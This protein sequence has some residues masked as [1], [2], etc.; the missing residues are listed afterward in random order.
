VGG[1]GG[2]TSRSRLTTTFG[3]VAVLA[4]L[5][6]IVDTDR[7]PIARAADGTSDPRRGEVVGRA[8]RTLAAEGVAALDGFLR[9]A[10]ITRVAADATSNLHRANLQNSAG[11]AYL[12]APDESFSEGHPRR[13]IQRSKTHVLAYDLVAADNPVRR[14]FES[15]VMTDFLADILD[16]HPLYR[17]ADPLGALNLTVMEAGHVQGWHY[18]STDFVVSIAIQSSEGG[19]AFECAQDIRTANDERYDDVARVLDDRADDLVRVYPMTPGTLMV[20]MGRHSIHRVAPVTG[21]TPR[22]VAL[23]GYDTKPDTNSSDGLKL[24]RYGRTEAIA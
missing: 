22:I 16:R 12:A 1:R 18:D 8:R 20:F 4:D 13:N 11:T 6:T 17:M 10:T 2:T 3:G 9:P 23:L 15:D 14:L 24:A 19:G 7:Y 21:A 5:D